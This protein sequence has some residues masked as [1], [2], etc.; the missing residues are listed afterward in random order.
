MM[1]RN[2]RAQALGTDG[3]ALQGHNSSAVLRGSSQG[4]S[5]EVELC[6]VGGRAGLGLQGLCLRGNPHPQDEER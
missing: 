3:Q 2:R 5:A 1:T 6:F 4:G